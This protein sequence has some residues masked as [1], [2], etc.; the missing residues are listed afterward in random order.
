VIPKFLNWD[1]IISMH[2]KVVVTDEVS[3]TINSICKFNDVTLG[4]ICV[5]SHVMPSTEEFLDFITTFVPENDA[6]LSDFSLPEVINGIFKN[7]FVCDWDELV[8]DRCG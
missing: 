3:C 8:S 6:N 2:D 4:D 5:S 7:W 1:E